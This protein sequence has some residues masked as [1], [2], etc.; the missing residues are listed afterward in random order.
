MAVV[1]KADKNNQFV[2]SKAF[3][4]GC[5]HGIQ[6]LPRNQMVNQDVCVAILNN[7]KTGI[8]NTSTFKI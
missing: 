2:S 4:M 1:S 5:V 6:M 3:K 7:R 8:L